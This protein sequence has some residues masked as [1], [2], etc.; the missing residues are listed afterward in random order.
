VDQGVNRGED[1]QRVS[2]V[3][4]WEEEA[5]GFIVLEVGRDPAHEC[6]GSINSNKTEPVQRCAS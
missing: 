5:E 3:E 6:S 4:L 1:L 2:A